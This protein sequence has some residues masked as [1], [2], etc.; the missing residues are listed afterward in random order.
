MEGEAGVLG[1][2]L[3]IFSISIQGM[4]Y[5]IIWLGEEWGGTY[6]IIWLGEEWGGTYWI[7]W[8]GEEWGGTYLRIWFMVSLR[9]APWNGRDPV[10]ISNMSTPYDHQSAAVP[11]PLRFTTCQPRNSY[12]HIVSN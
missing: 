7:I 10:S 12:S 9:F 4:T 8:L 11:C 3:G 2:E 1:L 5:W 6:W